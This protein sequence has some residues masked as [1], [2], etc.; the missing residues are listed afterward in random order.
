MTQYLISFDA[1]AMDHIPDEDMRSAST[2]NSTRCWAKHRADANGPAPTSDGG[3]G[4]DRAL[5]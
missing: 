5:P 1:H 3:D 4:P 2:R